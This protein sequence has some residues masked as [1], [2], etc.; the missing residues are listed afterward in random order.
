M[1]DMAEQDDPGTGWKTD[2]SATAA[3]AVVAVLDRDD[4]A[5]SAILGNLTREEAVRTAGKLAEIVAGLI[6]ED[7]EGRARS[8]ATITEVL[9]VHAFEPH[10]LGELFGG[11][12][13]TGRP[14]GERPG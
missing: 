8:R 12:G 1:P 5:L 14:D 11:D 7:D 4:K 3:A 6:A 2:Y 10:R 9:R 13:E